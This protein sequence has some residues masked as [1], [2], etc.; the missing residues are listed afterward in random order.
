M[1]QVD[2]ERYVSMTEAAA[3]LEVSEE[4]LKDLVNTGE[5]PAY[6]LG[7]FFLRFRKDQVDHLKYKWRIERSMYPSIDKPSE[8]DTPAEFQSWREKL[9]DFFYFYDFYIVCAA[10]IVAILSFIITS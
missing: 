9:K 2:E 10:L 7:G 4:K 6:T 5:L 3:I 1:E 8:E